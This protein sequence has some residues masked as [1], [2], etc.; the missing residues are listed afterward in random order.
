MGDYADIESPGDLLQRDPGLEGGSSVE[1]A[2]ADAGFQVQAVNWVWEKVVGEDLVSSIIT[3]ITGDFEKIAQGAAQWNNVRDALQA[4]RNN[5]NNGLTEL[6]PAWQGPAATSFHR[7]IGILWTT[8]IEADAQVAK[9]IGIALSKVADGS[10]RACDQALELIEK[11][12]NKLIEAAA[13]LPIPVVGWAR[14]VKIV[15]DGIQIYNAIMDLIDGIQ[16]II[17]GAKAVLE[18]VQSVGSALGQLGEANNLNDVINAGNTGVQGAFDIKG[19]VDD[20]RSG[21]TSVSSAAGDYA[22]A[23]DS[24]RDNARG[25]AEERS[26]ARQ[27][28][29]SGS[30]TTGAPDSGGAPAGSRPS[31][32]GTQDSMAANAG[33]ENSESRPGDCVP[34]SGDPVDLATGQ[35][36]MTQRDLELP[37]LLTLVFE[38]T[39]FS[40][41]RVGRFFGRSWASTV[42]QRIEVEPDA[43]YFA[44][45]DGARLKYPRPEPGGASVLPSAGSMWPLSCTAEGLYRI[46]QPKTG[47]TLTFL[48]GTRVQQLASVQDRNGNRIDVRYDGDVPAELVHSAGYRLGLDSSDGLVT[49]LWLANPSGPPITVASYDYN[50]RRQLV[51]VYNSSSQAMRFDYDAEGRI[52][53]WTDRNGEWYRYHYDA[54]GRVTSSSGSGDALTGSWEYDDTHRIRRYTDAVGATTTY[55]F[56]ERWQLVTETDPLGATTTRQWTSYNDLLSVTDPLGRTV[57]REIDER[58]NVTRVTQADGSEVTAEY[59]A[60]GLPTRIVEPDG[61]TWQRF[62]DDAGNLVSFADPTGAI[63]R[64]T[65]DGKG[66][67]TS[68][69]DALGNTR[70]VETDAAGL[71]VNVVDAAGGT[72]RY[73]RDVFGR[74]S[75]IVDPSGATTRMSWTIEGRLLSRTLPDGSTERWRYDG[76]GNVVEHVDPVGKRTRTQYGHFDLPVAQTAPDGARL[77]FTHDAAL[78]LVAV[79]NPQGLVWR[80]TYDAAGRLTS[81]VDFNGRELRYEHDEAGQLIARVNGA[82]ERVEFTRDALGNVV[83]KRAG[84]TVTTYEFDAAGRLLSAASPDAELRYERDAVGRVLTETV[85]G[86]AVRSV[87]DVLG[88]RISRTT[89]SGAE[90][91][92]AYD[93]DG[94]PRTLTSGG[95]TM[96]F[97]YDAAGREVRRQ[98]DAGAAIAQGWDANHR[99]ASQT[100]TAVDPHRPTGAARVVQQRAYRYH[101]DGYLAVIDDH[102]GGSRRFELDAAGRIT[103]VRGQGWTEQYAYDAAGNVTHGTWPATPDGTGNPESQGPREYTGTIVRRAGGT[104]YRHDAQGRVVQRSRRTL[105]G[106]QQTWTFTWNAE[107]HLVAVSTPDGSRWRYVYD[108][109]GRRIAKHRLSDADDVVESVEFAWDGVTVAEQAVRGSGAADGVTT[110]DFAPGSFRPIT[111]RERGRP[112]TAA[113][114]SQEWVDRQFYALV[115]DLVG[116]PMEMVA[117]DGDLA[118]R[119][120]TTVWGQAV[121]RLTTGPSCPLRFPGQYHDE[122]TGDN[123]NFFRYY[124]PAAGHYTAADPLGLEGG[125]NQHRYVANP[126]RLLDPLGLAPQCHESTR[127]ELGNLGE[128]LDDR[129]LDAARREIGGEVVARKADGT[130]YDHI[131]EVANSQQG[132]VNEIQAMERKLGHPGL[133]EQTRV[134]T[135]DRLSRYSRFLD[136]TEQWVPH[137]ERKARIS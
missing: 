27:D 108:P 131:T 86:S 47:R 32:S 128:A 8:G 98:L 105:S 89:P 51:A 14:A 78:R 113:T 6:Q 127:S 107:D 33:D 30:G 38:R 82:G 70:R 111:Q 73:V 79:R 23:R 92:W 102:L 42:D 118:W 11:L 64:Y 130:P 74:V 22:D 19:G 15:Y 44:A 26:N 84:D 133:E 99:L 31:D 90:S 7:E 60:F 63:T 36:F 121:A 67:L 122:E 54:E 137:E 45:P 117:P 46:E 29:T 120:Q 135:T 94:R 35:M 18:G 119:N 53:Q 68:V 72:T 103:A 88:R 4:V 50:D 95:N 13:M 9:T 37:G 66:A 43:V 52:T 59:N 106:R 40:G 76:E 96:S 25:L 115:T 80:Y 123:Y 112:E 77:E 56:N 61:A 55:G 114:A 65:Y 10:K 132:V 91:T 5:L 21:A 71:P 81:E 41:Y 57:R 16:K 124:D 34:G 87:Y 100:I 109:I 28:G 62:Y 83:E 58:G 12:V 49:R 75:S 126:Y 101:Q 1:D 129:H 104:V 3:P 97:A 48:P 39:H 93:A 125:P 85:N 20:V 136:Y 69:T 17:E 2:I 24:A 134:D 116:T 110:W